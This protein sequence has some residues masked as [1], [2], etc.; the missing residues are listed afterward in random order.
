[1]RAALLLILLAAPASAACQGDTVF[2]CQ[3][4]K[5]TLEVC[6]AKAMLTYRFGPEGKPDLTITEPLE[7]VTFT[8]WP[9]VGRYIWE[10]LAFRNQGFTYEIWTSVERGPEAVTGLQAAVTVFEG[11]TEI[12]RLTCDEGTPTNSLDGVYDLKQSIGQCWDF[13]S[14][15][16]QRDCS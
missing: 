15:S 16:W 1:M 8:P 9:G 12:A 3:I 14:Q 2:S 5:K 11:D 6:H 10:T 7:T 4:G 13:G